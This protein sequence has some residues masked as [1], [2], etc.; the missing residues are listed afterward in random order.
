V[1]GLRSVGLLLVVAT[2]LAGCGL[3]PGG[4]PGAGFQGAG[5]C[6]AMPG[7]VCQEQ[8]DLAAARHP[9]ATQVDVTCT[10]PLCDR[11]G[12]SGTVVVTLA[13]G[14]TVTETFAYTGDPT[15]L[16]APS[17]SGMAIDLC[18]SLATSAVDQLPPRKVIAAISIACTASSCTQARGDADVRVRF[19]DGSEFAS[20]TG[21][22]GA[23]P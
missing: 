6:S 21:W 20:S 22:E 1:T 15:P 19:A 2:V 16:P 3:L 13:N 7:G 10:A 9:G 4:V 18:R 5:G 14:A 11:K 12:G 23:T 17:C 8:L